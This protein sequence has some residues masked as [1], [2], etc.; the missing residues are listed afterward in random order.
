[1]DE[2]A[3]RRVGADEVIV[4]EVVSAERVYSDL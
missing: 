3:A 2:A 1:M 4:P